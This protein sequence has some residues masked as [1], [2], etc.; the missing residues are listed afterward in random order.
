MIRQVV[1][2]MV[3]MYAGAAGVHMDC[4]QVPAGSSSTLAVETIMW[5]AVLWEQWVC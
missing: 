1:H 2:G 3:C 4:M 5:T